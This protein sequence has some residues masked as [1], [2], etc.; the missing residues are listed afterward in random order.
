MTSFPA[1]F[2]LVLLLLPGVAFPP[3]RWES[4]LEWLGLRISLSIGANGL[5]FGLLGWTGTLTATSVA[6]WAILCVVASAATCW[7]VREALADL[8]RDASVADAATLAFA[9]LFA[10]LA[11]YWSWFFP[12]RLW[13]SLFY[14]LPV[15]RILSDS[16][17][18][19]AYW[20]DQGRHA[21]ILKGASGGNLLPAFVSGFLTLEP[22]LHR[23]APPAVALA[24]LGSCSALVSALDDTEGLPLAAL[25]VAALSPAVVYQSSGYHADLLLATLLGFTL[26]ASLRATESLPADVDDD[27]PLRPTADE[28]LVGLLALFATLP[29]RSGLLVVALPFAVGAWRSLAPDPRGWRRSDAPRL[30]VVGAPPLLAAASYLAATAGLPPFPAAAGTAELSAFFEGLIDVGVPLLFEVFHPE[31]LGP[32]VTVLFCLVVTARLLLGRTDDHRDVDLYALVVVVWTAVAAAGIWWMNR[33]DWFRHWTRYLLPI[34][35]VACACV[36]VALWSFWE[37]SD[38]VPEDDAPDD[39]PGQRALGP[40]RLVVAAA[41][42]A[43]VWFLPVPELAQP[44]FFRFG[45]ASSTPNAP[46]ARK[47]EEVDWGVNYP[48]WKRAAAA[49]ERTD[50]HILSAD[51]RIWYMLDSETVVYDSRS[52]PRRADGVGAVLGWLRD[53]DVT[54]LFESRQNPNLRL[55]RAAKRRGVPLEAAAASDRF[56]RVSTEGPYRIWV[57]RVARN[58]A[59]R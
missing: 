30:A 18:L 57:R 46:L 8:A 7:H 45:D 49:A 44:L 21:L 15:G 47:V 3:R 36:V 5:L 33:V 59:S 22:P 20:H 13:D 55:S 2:A 37:A 39:E 54:V 14:H 43:L 23:A 50:G 56:E 27:S 38:D 35:G 42:V 25:G 17:L 28:I 26:V 10:G 29:K 53:H 24:F 6:I 4:P 58:P 11:A 16:Q 48:G 1:Y 12:P 51:T 34:Q 52:V 19:G 32:H 9:L 40:G 31:V 41:G